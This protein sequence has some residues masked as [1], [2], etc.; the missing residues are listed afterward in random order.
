MCMFACV[1]I[2]D[3]L[4]MQLHSNS[5]LPIGNCIIVYPTMHR[6]PPAT[7]AG[8]SQPP[9]QPSVVPMDVDQEEDPGKTVLA[10]EVKPSDVWSNMGENSLCVWS[11]LG[12]T[13][14]CMRLSLCIPPTNI[15]HS[16]PHSIHYPITPT[17]LPHSPSGRTREGP[18]SPWPAQLPNVGGIRLP[19][20]HHQPRPLY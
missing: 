8:P 13:H 4:L 15:P 3:V 5:T 17:P 16:T 14:V 6:Q 10:F 11:N 20:R 1:C 7:A 19:Q 9:S 12:I 18:L 2:G